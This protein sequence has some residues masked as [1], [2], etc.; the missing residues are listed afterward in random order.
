MLGFSSH[1]RIPCTFAT[2]AS[3]SSAIDVR[4]ANH[5]S[6]EFVTFSSYLGAST[7]NVYVQACR[8]K[9][10][11]FRRVVDQ[12]T[13][14]SSVGIDDWEVPS[15]AGNRTVVCW[16]AP[17]FDFVKIELSRVTTASMGCWVNVHD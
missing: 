17:M 15:F 7:A 10:G 1:Q 9:D 8:S 2:G 4:G 12:G 11:T 14:S 6:F 16:P 3:C 5:V 13:Y